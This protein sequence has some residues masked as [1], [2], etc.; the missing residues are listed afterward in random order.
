MIRIMFSKTI[1]IFLLLCLTATFSFSQ[2]KDEIINKHLKAR[3]NLDSLKNLKNLVIVGNIQTA[4]VDLP[5]VYMKKMPSKIRFQ[6][7]INGKTAVTVFDAD[8]GWISDPTSGN[9]LPKKLSTSEVA[10]K[11]PLIAYLMVFFDD[12]LLTC[13]RNII[14]YDGIEKQGN[15]YAHKLNVTMGDGTKICYYIDTKNYIDY[16]H[17]VTFP[18]LNTTFTVTLNNFANS[19]GLNFPLE[20]ES[21]IQDQKI[22]KLTI[23]QLKINGDI[24]D[25]VFIMP[26]F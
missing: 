1:K 20:I 12:L 15:N 13:P 16:T 5:M 11:K 23:K 19:E 22:T 8:S 14:T 3:G 18:D 2:T 9:M 17:K 25:S 21:R 7:D 6:V 26:K 4:G 24:D 10:Q